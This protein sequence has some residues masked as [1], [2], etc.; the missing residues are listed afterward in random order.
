M[1]SLLLTAVL[2]LSLLAAQA[3]ANPDIPVAGRAAMR[4]LVQDVSRAV[5]ADNP[6][7]IVIVQNALPL[8]LP[9]GESGTEEVRQ[10][11]ESMDGLAIESF[12]FLPMNRP[13]NPLY[14]RPWLGLLQELRAEGK[15]ILVTEYLNQSQAI[16]QARR[17]CHDQGF[18]LYAARTRELDQLPRHPRRPFQVHKAPV[19]HLAAARNYLFLINPHKYQDKESFVRQLARTEHD[20]LIVDPWFRRQSPLTGEDI[21]RLQ[22]KPGGAPRPVLA[23]LSIGE[24]ENYRS[25]WEPAWKPGKPDWLL[26]EN[27]EW[28]GNFPVRYWDPTW[29]SILFNR[30]NGMISAILR[31]GFDGVLLDT[32]DSY[33]VHEQARAEKGD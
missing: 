24:A 1:P 15:S 30:K 33:R 14:Y 27:P 6:R 20:L 23:Y 4:L 26:P 7:R 3:G 2:A 22:R 17:L 31:A 32:V 8:L 19:P 13:R 16:E 9:D 21:R 18:L 25:Y 11:R 29:R 28:P 12:Y 10:Y 5:K